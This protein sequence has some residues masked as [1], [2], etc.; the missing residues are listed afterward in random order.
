MLQIQVHIELPKPAAGVEYTRALL[1]D[2]AQQWLLGKKLPANIKV[3][4]L[5]WRT[6]PNGKWKEERD[7]R[8]MKNVRED[9]RFIAQIGF[10]STGVQTVG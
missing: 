5:E 1:D 4:A 8:R 7:P 6:G 2:I 3:R 10:S 9:F